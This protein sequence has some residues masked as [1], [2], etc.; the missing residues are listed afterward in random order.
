MTSNQTTEVIQGQKRS[1][2]RHLRPSKV[3]ETRNDTFLPIFKSDKTYLT[4]LRLS[5]SYS[6]EKSASAST[7]LSRVISNEPGAELLKNGHHWGRLKAEVRFWSMIRYTLIRL[8]FIPS[9]GLLR[10]GSLRFR[11]C[12][13]FSTKV[14]NHTALDCMMWLNHWIWPI[15]MGR[16]V[17]ICILV[18]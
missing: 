1:S 13:V 5:V 6:R 3:S 18:Q 2:K 10:L 4:I 12:F 9:F 14:L 11:G 7:I 15:R 16:L 17:F 8:K